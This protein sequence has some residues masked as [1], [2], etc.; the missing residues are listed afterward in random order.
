MEQE[1]RDMEPPKDFT[2]I[3]MTQPGQTGALAGLM[4]IMKVAEA[5]RRHQQMVELITSEIWNREKD[6]M[7]IPG[8]NRE[9]LCLPGAQKLGY[10]FGLSPQYELVQCIEDWTGEAH[11]GTPLFDYTYKCRLYSGERL[12]AEADGNCNSWEAKYRWRWVPASD[13]PMGLDMKDLKQRGGKINE[14]KFAIEKGETTGKYGK[15]AEYWEMFRRAIEGKEYEVESRQS[16]SG[17]MV[18]WIIIESVLYRVPNDDIASLKNTIMK[19]AQKRAY[20]GSIMTACNASEFFSQDLEDMAKETLDHVIEGHATVLSTEG[21]KAPTSGK[22]EGLPL[23]AKAGTRS[24]GNGGNGKGEQASPPQ[25]SG[26][27]PA[28]PRESG[29]QER[30]MAP[31]AV[32]KG[33]APAKAEGKEENPAPWLMNGHHWSLE[34]LVMETLTRFL[35]QHEWSV[36]DVLRVLNE[37]G[38]KYERLEEVE[39]ALGDV[40]NAMLDWSKA[41]AAKQEAEKR[42]SPK[43]EPGK[44]L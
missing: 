21:K 39:L 15:P 23:P 24:G 9:T 19:M 10:F 8:A 3:T 38:Q 30:R 32:R 22:A 1:V 20:V 4:P 16:K 25:D 27:K 28:P 17:S 14:P 31:G 12:I 41:E 26:P 18:E 33:T 13:I 29:D 42:Q 5:I 40:M 36:G 44:L 2:A 11:G 37:R 43:P 7:V 34:P 35:A 6:S